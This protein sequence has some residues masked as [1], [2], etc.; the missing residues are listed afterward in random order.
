MRV[1]FFF[2]LGCVFI[3]SRAAYA[4]DSRILSAKDIQT[5]QQI[6]NAHKKGNYQTS[7]NL[8]RSLSNKLLMGYILYDRYLST[9]YKTNRSE[10]ESWLKKYHKLPVATDIYVL[11]QKKKV[12]LK[13]L[14]P[15]D[16]L[17]G[18][19]SKACSYVR[20]DEAIDALSNKNFPYVAEMHKKEAQRHYYQLYQF[21]QKGKTKEAA[22]LIDSD[23][24][25]KIFNQKD[26]DFARTALAFSFFLQGKDDEALKQ[27]KKAIKTSGEEIPLAYWTAGLCSWRL[28]DYEEAG[29]YFASAA[30]HPLN[31][32]ILRGSAA[33][34]AAR[35][36]LKL[37]MY[38]Q[39]GD[40]LELAAQQPRTFYG[41]LALRMLGESLDHVWDQ[42]SMPQDD[43]SVRFSHPALNRFYALKQ[44]GKKEWAS[45]ELA[46]LYLEASKEDR[47]LLMSVS[48]RHGFQKDLI[49]LAGTFEGADERF[50]APNWHP[51]DGWKVDKALVFSFVRQESCF[52]KRAKSS[53]G[54]RGLMQIMPQ[55]GRSI[56]RLAGLQWSANKMDNEAYNLTLGQ[57]YL[58]HLMKLPAVNYNLLFTAV[59]YNAG[60]GNLIKWKKQ[61]HY[62]D[63]P[64]LFI[65]SIPSRETR[66]FVERIMVNY[67][68]YRS[69]MGDSLNSLD[70]IISGKWP[71][72]RKNG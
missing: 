17:Y 30:T 11:G 8:S 3:F 48:A 44:I 10:I 45:K 52:N 34:W 51:Q 19:K 1:I 4:V 68:V 43:V 6:F 66:S 26:V 64:L 47:A 38:E 15:K 29:D 9:K 54:A 35:S 18:G 32:P 16:T 2:I 63:D 25:Q 41:M 42:P 56:A 21:I 65:E 28:E 14:K 31:Y 20:R 61:M 50:P 55:T 67:W 39:V 46:K 36:Y 24:F 37:G 5:Y 70:H 53:V 60:P 33:F 72:Y 62:Q 58:L 40:Y 71:V 49:R 7:K 23:F 12:K 27:A 57:N 69:L 22:H 13:G 59:A